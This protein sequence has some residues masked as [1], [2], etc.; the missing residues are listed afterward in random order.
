MSTRSSVN[1]PSRRFPPLPIRRP[2]LNRFLNPVYTTRRFVPRANTA[3]ITNTPINT[4]PLKHSGYSEEQARLQRLVD[5]LDEIP[6]DPE[7]IDEEEDDVDEDIEGTYV[8][9]TDNVLQRVDNILQPEEHVPDINGIEENDDNQSQN[10]DH[11]VSDDDTPIAV[12][13]YRKGITWSDDY[14][15]IARKN[16][17]RE[18]TGPNIEAEEPIDRRTK[19]ATLQVNFRQ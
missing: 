2:L 4:N 15:N 8:I 7:S 1:S 6:S 17:F 10:D 19:P 5:V 9:G 11:D 14:P 18:H 16:E 3:I 12:R 13:L